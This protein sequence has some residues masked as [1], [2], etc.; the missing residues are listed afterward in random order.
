MNESGKVRNYAVLK[1]EHR[2]QI[3]QEEQRK[4][5]EDH[6]AQQRAE[7]E[8]QKQ[9]ALEEEEQRKK[10]EALKAQQQKE[11]ADKQEALEQE[12]QGQKEEALKA[13]QVKEDARKQE[14]LLAERAA[15]ENAE[16]LVQ[17]AQEMREVEAAHQRLEAYKQEQTR[18]AAE[19]RQHA[20]ERQR[21]HPTEGEIRNA[22]ARYAQALGQHYDVRDPYASLAR[23]SM[24]EYGAFIR[25]RENLNRQIAQAKD[26]AQR[27]RLELRRDIEAADYMAITSHRIASQSELITGKLN[28]EEAQKQR[29][30][31]AGYE[32]QGRELR[33]QWRERHQ[34][35]DGPAPGDKKPAAEQPSKA[36]N[37]A[38][39]GET[40]PSKE[41][42]R[43]ARARAHTEQLRQA[44]KERARSQGLER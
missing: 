37:P 26:P 1:D 6:A 28:G 3:E 14:A 44:N 27:E 10:E 38:Q 9:K 4:Q 41:Q 19:A 32:A 7:D 15:Q 40:S 42:E 17:Q 21:E 25:D 39:E 36:P 24:A 18:I 20:R 34:G 13:E 29:A 8:A 35:R 33:A 22:H 11:E 16:R 43:L 31:A 5:E 12:A 30:R 23:S 2:K